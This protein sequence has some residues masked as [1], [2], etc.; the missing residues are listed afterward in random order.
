MLMK[1]T[2][3]LLNKD[4]KAATAKTKHYQK[5]TCFIIS[6]IVEIGLNITYAT[7]VISRSALNPSHLHSKIIKTIFCYPKAFKN[8]EILYEGEQREDLIIKRYSNSDRAGNY[9]IK[10][11]TL[12]FI[13]ILNS[14][15]V[16]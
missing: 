7:L 13:F 8:I 10:K 2:P 9:I 6:L 16:S 12:G 1:K 14:R 15:S 4:K 3:L 11:F 5:M